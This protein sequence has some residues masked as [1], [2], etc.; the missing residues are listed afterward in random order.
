MALGADPATVSRSVLGQSLE[1]AA[2]RCVIGLA[3]AYAASRG[4]SSLVYHVRP[5][6]PISVVGAIALITV[7]ALAAAP[8]PVRQ[9]LSI[10]PA[11]SLR[12]E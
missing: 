4:L 3:G 12:T 2:V 6:D 5:A 7:V 11:D 9:A 1:L 10:D 8:M